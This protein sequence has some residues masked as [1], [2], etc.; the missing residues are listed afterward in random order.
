MKKEA[1]EKVFTSW[2]VKELLGK[3]AFGRVYR[4]ER[5]EFG[6]LYEAAMK[7]ITIPQ[8]NEEIEDAVSEGMDEQSVTSYFK[9][10]VE[11]I[12]NEFKL[13]A[14]LKGHTNIVSYEDHLV[15]PHEDGIGWDILIRMELLKS[16]KTLTAERNL[17]E[18]EV[19]KLGI[20]ICNALEVCG[21][22]NIIHRDI[23]PENIFISNFGEFKL[24][25]FGIART[26]EK[27]MSNLSK[28]GTY[29]YMAPEVY[30]G[31]AYDATV[32]IYSLGI[33]M[34]RFM[35]YNRA[36]FLPAYPN[37]ISF[38]DREASLTRRIS[39]EPMPAPACGSKELK[40]IILKACAYQASARYQS[41]VQLRS[42][43]EKLLRNPEP[44]EEEN[45]AVKAASAVP[46]TPVMQ[47]EETMTV[48]AAAGTMAMAAK[49]LEEPEETAT[50]SAWENPGKA[51]ALQ[52]PETDAASGEAGVSSL[53]AVQE[54]PAS[55]SESR[56]WD[57]TMEEE[58]STVSMFDAK[59]E[60]IRSKPVSGPAVPQPEM[61]AGPEPPKKKKTGIFIVIGIVLVLIVAAVVIVASIGGGSHTAPQSDFDGFT[62]LDEIEEADAGSDE[63]TESE[64][65]M[66]TVEIVPLS[67]KYLYGHY[68][69]GNSDGTV[70]KDF[71]D[72]VGSAKI[73]GMTVSAVPCEMYCFP[74]GTLYRTEGLE[75][76]I[77]E[78]GGDVEWVETFYASRA[79]MDD[80]GL[81]GEEVFEGIIS[82]W[83]GD[84]VT[85]DLSVFYEENIRGKGDTAELVYLTEEMQRGKL[86]GYY[87]VKDSVMEFQY[88]SIDPEGRLY[89]TLITYDVVFENGDLIVS[90]DGAAGKLRPEGVLSEY[91][92]YGAAGYTSNP[93]EPDLGISGI[94]F[95]VNDREGTRFSPDRNELIEGDGVFAAVNFTDG[96]QAEDAA[97]SMGPGNRIEIE[98]SR[99]MSP[100]SYDIKEEEG[101]L[102]AYYLDCGY[103]G[104][105]LRIDGKD[106]FYQKTEKEYYADL[107]GASVIDAEVGLNI[108]EKMGA[109]KR[110]IL[111][112]MQEAMEEEFASAGHVTEDVI[113]INEKTGKII[114]NDDV[115]FDVNSYELSA[116]GMEYLSLIFSAMNRVIEEEGYGDYID[117]IFLDCHTDS[118]GN[119]EENQELSEA[120]ADAVDDYCYDL[121]P[122]LSGGY[123]DTAGYAGGRLI[124]DENGNEDR[125]ASGRVEIMIA[126][127]ADVFIDEEE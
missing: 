116:E 101:N 52:K 81:D 109:A 53:A 66:E 9:S 127:D 111:L 78:T 46:F 125:D 30:K 126:L 67:E 8:T 69:I 112:T 10:F 82:C 75:E 16:L 33:V 3:G 119:Y 22:M 29:T 48:S 4:L 70:E 105:I 108:L 120:R 79:Y 11:E 86:I 49:E 107:V 41:P 7:K 110:E 6:T 37:P 15:I 93:A 114:L 32:D 55:Q 58:D 72:T 115:L 62:Y 12:V 92:G 57:D 26:A 28:K 14:Q 40:R 99:L 2:T 38:S 73:S 84:E 117:T 83:F 59:P 104:C 50:V 96:Y 106:Y 43:L 88:L 74:E 39:E 19:I 89:M 54:T 25:D 97:A 124:Y 5:E 102:S 123:I 23:K 76:L 91:E 118:T 17:T 103:I 44:A 21:K 65:T 61:S 36:P 47:E 85:T 68:T 71:W 87:Q 94:S 122:A 13:M 121:Y 98:W 80:L 18:E 77:D 45:N 51:A 100:D 90:R 35:N 60:D 34:Y 31:E 63:E 27:T 1:E 20:D 24:G 42:D 113:A 95:G 64:E 56:E